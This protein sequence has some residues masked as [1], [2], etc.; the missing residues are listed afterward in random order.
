MR[1]NCSYSPPPSARHR[2]SGSAGT[3]ALSIWLSVDPMS[4]KY[5]GVSQ[6]VYCA[7]NPVRLIEPDGRDW[8][9]V[10]NDDRKTITFQ[11]TFYTSKEG[12]KTES[13]CLQKYN[14][15]GKIEQKP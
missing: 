6:Y 9:V 7:N 3:S 13:Q 14:L 1:Q 8:V 12:S 4:D 5:P 2:H 11:A 15:H 10:K